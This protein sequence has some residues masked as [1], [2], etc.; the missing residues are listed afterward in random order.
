MH[1][2]QCVRYKQM[3]HHLARL[4]TNQ[5]AMQRDQNPDRLDIGALSQ[6]REG[7]DRNSPGNGSGGDETDAEEMA[8][9]ARREA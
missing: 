1:G 8:K 6:D 5:T 7:G 3:Q 2:A 9:L 4:E